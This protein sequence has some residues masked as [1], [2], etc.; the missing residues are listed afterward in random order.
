MELFNWTR[1]GLMS[2]L[3]ATAGAA[4]MSG[5]V[6]LGAPAFAQTPEGVLI[7][8][9]IAEPKS[10]DPAA[11]T[12]VNDF[13]ILVNLY[14]GLVKY[15]PGTLEV[16]PGLATSWEISED[17][18][19]YTFHLREGVMFHDGTPFNAEAVKFNF[20][21]MLNEDHPYYNTG[22]FPLAFFFSA[23]EETTAVDT[24]TVKFKLNGPYA[25]FLSNLAYPTGLMVSPAAVEANGVDF[26]RNPA[27]TGPFKFAEWRSNEAVVIEKNPDYWGDP[28]GTEAVVFRP[29]TDANTRVAEM[30]AGGID[31]MVEVPPTALSQFQSDAFNIVE[32]AG[33]HLWFLILNAKEG[34]FADKRVRQAANYAINKEALVNDVL[35]GTADV[36]AGPT[37][38][39]FAWAYNEALDPYPYDPEKAKELLAE[40]GAEGASL[41][42]YVTEGGSGMLDPIP[43]GTA[44]QADLEAVGLDVKIET[45]EWNTFLGE[46]NPGLEGKADMAEMAWMTNDPDTLPFLA[47]RTEAWPDKG[48]F[49]SGYYSNPE[50][51]ALLEKAR[52]STNQEE[53]ATLYK[54]MQAIVQEDA[55]WVFVA[56]WKQNAVTTDRVGNFS[57]EPSF[58][59]QLQSVTKE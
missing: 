51:D 4:L 8:G 14:E 19:E 32:Q 1:R 10:L 3:M 53:R 36:A 18:T 28:A 6:T 12:A 45:Y 47:L 24:Y 39:A 26:G 5:L 9:Q 58:L 54:E 15:A 48:G 35:E 33:P 23:I 27:G 59:L 57:L 16:A 41:T 21:R 13:R 43:M 42:F 37:P 40:A 17:G 49:N 2:G 56:N 50:V 34:P 25:P 7:V 22:P 11:V 52:V 55:P 46:V 30:L 44:I 31:M 20:D 29:I 38:P